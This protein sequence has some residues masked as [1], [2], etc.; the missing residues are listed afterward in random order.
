MKWT[1]IYMEP[2]H[3]YY[4]YHL[5]KQINF[6]NAEIILIPVKTKRKPLPLFGGFHEVSGHRID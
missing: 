5:Q 3:C 6:E 4:C 2:S 1:Y